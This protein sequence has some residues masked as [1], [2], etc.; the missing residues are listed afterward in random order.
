MATITHFAP[1]RR[2]VSAPG[3]VARLSASL[4][5]W[6]EERQRRA[7]MWQELS[8][9]TDRDLSDLGFGRADFAAIVAGTYRR[10]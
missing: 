5:S 2:Q 8:L 7:R 4:R 6:R 3:L 10:D 9:L 1:A